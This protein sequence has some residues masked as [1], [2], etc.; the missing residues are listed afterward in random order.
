MSNISVADAKNHLPR[1]LHQVEAGDA[2]HIT[3]RGKAVAVL[4]S[5]AAYA[6]LRVQQN[7]RNFWVEIQQMRNQAD[8]EGIDLTAEEIADWR[9]PEEGRAFQ[10][11][12]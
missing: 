12:R 3:R 10:W 5:E 2:I 4:L 7:K 1:L 11:E 6:R 9:D 8:F